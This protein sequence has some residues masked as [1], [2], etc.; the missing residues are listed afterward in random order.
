MW[1]SRLIFRGELAI[2]TN[3]RRHWPDWLAMAMRGLCGGYAA[4]MRRGGGGYA[5][6]AIS[7]AVAHV[8]RQLC[9]TYMRDEVAVYRYISRRY[10]RRA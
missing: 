6:A 1:A 9:G 8:R 4:A 5:A 7:Y 2:G 3:D 10:A